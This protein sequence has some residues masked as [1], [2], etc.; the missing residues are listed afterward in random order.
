MNKPP[1]EPN[2]TWECPY[3]VRRVL[4][5]GTYAEVLEVEGPWGQGALKRTREERQTPQ[6]LA[7][8]RQEASILASLQGRCGWVRLLEPLHESPD[9]LWFV[10]ES[11]P[12][13][14]LRAD[15][16][17]QLGRR[18]AQVARGLDHLHQQGYWHRDLSLSNLL[19]DDQGEVRLCD[20]GMCRDS[21]KPGPTPDFWFAHGDPE[22][23]APERLFHVESGEMGDAYSLGALL[24]RL[25][26]GKSHFLLSPLAQLHSFFPRQMES[27]FRQCIAAGYPCPRVDFRPVL[28]YYL[29]QAQ[30]PRLEAAELTLPLSDPALGLVNQLLQDL[31][32]PDPWRRLQHFDSLK[33]VADAL[34]QLKGELA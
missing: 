23:T 24:F 34:E 5:L 14:T 26:S 10:M 33:A 13:G 16:A 1:T 2:S 28:D 6:M 9:G 8:F 29:K 11:L 15:N 30:A 21:Q 12:G 19:L 31:M 7:R 25:A 4:G 27:Y 17:D 3:P 32:Q 20:L 22:Y 18:L